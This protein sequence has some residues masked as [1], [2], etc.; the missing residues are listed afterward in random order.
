M[1][2]AL[3]VGSNVGAHASGSFPRGKQTKRRMSWRHAEAE[4]RNGDCLLVFP[5]F[6]G[7]APRSDSVA[8]SLVTKRRTKKFWGTEIFGLLRG[9]KTV[10]AAR[11]LKRSAPVHP[12]PP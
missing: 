6:E 2:Y 3:V 4:S 5:F 9:A 7:S 1:G 12:Y 8:A 11:P 10:G